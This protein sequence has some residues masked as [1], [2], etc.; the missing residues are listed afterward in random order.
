MN[1]LGVF[2]MF[3]AYFITIAVFL[4]TRTISENQRFSIVLKGIEENS[5]SKW[6]KGNSVGIIISSVG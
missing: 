6:F 4:Y 3:Q 2:K 1:K 5:G